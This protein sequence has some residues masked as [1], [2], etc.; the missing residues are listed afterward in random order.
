[1]QFIWVPNSL[2]HDT[3][4][5]GVLLNLFVPPRMKIADGSGPGS[6][7]STHSAHA[8]SAPT[9]CVSVNYLFTTYT[10]LLN[11]ILY[12]SQ[13][14][15]PVIQLSPFLCHRLTSLTIMWWLRCWCLCLCIHVISVTCLWHLC[16]CR[17]LHCWRVFVQG[18]YSEWV[19]GTSLR[20]PSPVG[21]EP[22]IR[23]NA[24]VIF[25]ARI[26]S[27]IKITWVHHVITKAHV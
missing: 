12:S 17:Q 14:H 18:R 25:C 24:E 7:N 10:L 23:S 21:G 3:E 26:D 19:Q 22:S 2:C 5:S 6:V 13:P 1:M 8:H 20:L 9:A 11:V 15:A 4:W 16:L 27:H